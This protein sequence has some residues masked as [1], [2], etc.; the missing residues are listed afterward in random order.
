MNSRFS[1][2]VGRSISLCPRYARGSFAVLLAAV[3]ACVGSAPRTAAGAVTPSG[4]VL[5]NPLTPNSAV[6]IANNA[7]GS[8][9]IDGGST[10]QSSSLTIGDG[11]LGSATVTGAGSH[12]TIDNSTEIG[13]FGIGQLNIRSGGAVDIGNGQLRVGVNSGGRG[14][15]VVENSGSLLQTMSQV[16]V[17]SNGIGMLRIADQA[18]VNIRSTG[19]SLTIGSSGRLEFADGLLLMEGNMTNNGVIAGDGELFIPSG[20]NQQNN[21][22]FEVQ[23]GERLLISGSTSGSI[24]NNG[25]IDADGGE[26]EFSRLVSNASSGGTVIGQITLRDAS[27]RFALIGTSGAGLNNSSVLAAYGG[28]NDIY[29][30]ITNLSAGKI[31]ATNDSSLIFHNNVTS[32][33]GT[34]SV[35]D[36]STAVFLQDLSLSGATLL[37]DLGGAQGFGHVEVVGNVVLGSGSVAAQLSNGFVPQVGDS[38]QLISAG[39]TISGPLMLGTMPALPTGLL[40]D[41]DVETHRVLLNVLATPPGDYNFNGVVDAADYVVW[42]K[43]AGQMGASLAADGNHDGKVDDAD[44]GVW[45]ANFGVTAQAAGAAALLATVPEPGAAMLLLF[46]AICALSRKSTTGRGRRETGRRGRR[47]RM[48]Q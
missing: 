3:I 27:V 7:M 35:F 44:Y 5:P 46:G 39:G 14:T 21:G 29:G 1:R 24:Q 38:F 36:G 4:D 16:M 15:V 34:I 9:L 10:F 31:S 19:T 8:L 28:V 26:F 33:G 40:W 17:G 30:R 32:Q 42:R 20:G 25:T 6:R 47:A 11:E 2:A 45:K 12:W 23:G 48:L 13:Y 41:L 43:S 37:A 22:R 18:L